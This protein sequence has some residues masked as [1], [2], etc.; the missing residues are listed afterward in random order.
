VDAGLS[1]LGP[2]WADTANSFRTPAV[3]TL[4]LG[5]RRRFELAGRAAEFRILGSNLN[6]QSGYLAA[7]SGLLSPIAP[8][9]LRAVLTLTFGASGHPAP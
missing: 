8:R 4:S 6:G 9:T 2:R 5:A 7:P 1:Y 3:T